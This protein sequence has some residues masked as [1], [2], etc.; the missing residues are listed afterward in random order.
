MPEGNKVL[1]LNIKSARA[2]AG[3]TQQQSADLIGISPLHYGRLER[4]DRRT[5]LEQIEKIAVIFGV[6][7]YALLDGIFPPSSLPDFQPNNDK[8]FFDQLQAM[9][10]YCTDDERLLCFDICQRI[11]RG[12]AETK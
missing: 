8:A 5:S 9:L 3:Y 11:I 7:P 2:K 10:K 1:S 12:K 6:S 4:G